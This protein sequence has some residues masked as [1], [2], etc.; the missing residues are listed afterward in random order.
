M[1]AFRALLITLWMTIAG[2]TAVVV[3]NHGLGLLPIF[4]GDMATMAWPGQ[5]NLDFLC[6]LTLS[7]LWVSWR[8]HF[9]AAGLVL[10]LLALFGGAFFLT[11]YLL[12]VSVQAKG[13]MH[14]ILLGKA[15]A[16][17]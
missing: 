6:M 4:F 13:Q 7:G 17:G 14:H 15:R 12:V 16:S 9:S 5:F 8:H 1:A 3:A 10:G 11:A 2:Y